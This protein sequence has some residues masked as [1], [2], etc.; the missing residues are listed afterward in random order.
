MDKITTI[1]AAR[2]SAAPYD[3]NNRNSRSRTP[4]SRDEFQVIYNLRQ[5]S[6]RVEQQPVAEAALKEASAVKPRQLRQRPIK[7]EEQPAAP[8]ALKEASAVKP[9]Q[10]RQRPIKSE[11][12]P[13]APAAL[14][15]ATSP[16]SSTPHQ[17]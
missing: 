1:R 15:E 4:A 9:R 7:S 2:H 17:V 12:Q 8:A 5:R 16:A 11:E 13:A 10:L 14:K 6:A 3:K